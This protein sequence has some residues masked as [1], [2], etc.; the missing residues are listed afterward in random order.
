MGT[1]VDG[2][3]RR[4][5]VVPEPLLSAPPLNFDAYTIAMSAIDLRAEVMQL[6]Q[7]EHN[8]SILATFVP[9]S[10]AKTKKGLSISRMMNL[11]GW[12]RSTAG[13]EPDWIPTSAWMRPCAQS[14]KVGGHDLQD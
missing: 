7:K 10:P 12:R 14:A 2:H 3:T 8:E 4:V 1:S 13:A 6:L 9:R 11:R 5:S